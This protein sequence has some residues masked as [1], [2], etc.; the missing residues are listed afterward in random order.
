MISRYSGN[1][2]FIFEHEDSQQTSPAIHSL[3]SFCER[4]N[5][6]LS[7]NSPEGVNTCL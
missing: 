4:I 7:T 2:D 5:Q 6:W 1:K 3:N